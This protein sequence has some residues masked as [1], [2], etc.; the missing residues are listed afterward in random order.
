MISSG[1]WTFFHRRCVRPCCGRAP[2]TSLLEV[3]LDLGRPPEA[4]LC[5]QD[6]PIWLPS[7]SMP[8][9]IAFVVERIGAFSHDNRAGIPAHPASHLRAP[10]P[11]RR[12][13]RPDLPGRTSRVRDARYRPGPGTSAGQEHPALRPARRVAKPPCYARRPACW[14]TRTANGSSSW[15][16][17][18]KLPATEIL[19]TPLSGAPGGCRSPHRNRQHQ[20]MIEAVENHMPEVIVVDEIGT[21]AEAE[22]AR[23]IAERGVRLI[24]TAHGGDPGEPR[25]ESNPV[26]PHWRRAVRHSG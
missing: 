8:K 10:Q 9:T 22:A 14:P 11:H 12:H 15:I 24:A 1:C 2:C 7:R 26:R 5:R 19:P 3:I 6:L 13:H 18:T 4:R 25:P 20:V 16:P 21:E 17:Q 23:T